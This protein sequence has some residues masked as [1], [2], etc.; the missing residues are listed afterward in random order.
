MDPRGHEVI[1]K[2]R[3]DAQGTASKTSSKNDAAVRFEGKPQRSAGEAALAD[4]LSRLSHLPLLTGEEE[5]E[6]ARQFRNPRRS[7]GLLA[8]GPR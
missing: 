1:E 7:L 8:G 5:R 4:Y 3:D 6:M 2:D